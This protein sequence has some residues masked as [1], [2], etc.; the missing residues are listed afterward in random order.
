[1]GLLRASGDSA[2]RQESAARF[3]TAFIWQLPRIRP[4]P[5]YELVC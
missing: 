2:L 5:E 3:A 1:M 4:S